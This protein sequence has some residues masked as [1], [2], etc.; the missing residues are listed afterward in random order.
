VGLGNADDPGNW[1]H[2]TW[3]ATMGALGSV[4][5]SGQYSYSTGSEWIH[6]AYVERFS[7]SGVFLNSRTYSEMTSFHE[8]HS[9]P[10]GTIFLSG[11]D[12]DSPTNL[13]RLNTNL[14]VTWSMQACTHYVTTFVVDNAGHLVIECE[15]EFFDRYLLK[16]DGDGNELWTVDLEFEFDPTMGRLAIDANDNIVRAAMEHNALRSTNHLRVEKFAP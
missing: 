7:S 2:D 8:I 1:Y 9:D 10:D 3:R 16:L 12:D 14:N 11:W 6:S 5:T 4:V 13:M 15:D